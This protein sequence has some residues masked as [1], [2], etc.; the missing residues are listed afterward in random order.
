MKTLIMIAALLVSSAACA[1]TVTAV[2]DGC[3]ARAERY[4]NQRTDGIGAFDSFVARTNEHNRNFFRY[5]EHLDCLLR[6][7]LTFNDELCSAWQPGI[8]PPVRC[9]KEFDR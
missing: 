4:A 5:T 2:W 7:S 8:V 6:H 3:E 9:W 1:G